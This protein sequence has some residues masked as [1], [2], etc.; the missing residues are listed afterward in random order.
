[1]PR[2]R[3]IL[4][5]IQDPI[6][7][8]LSTVIGGPPGKRARLGDRR[9]WLPV[10]VLVFFAV[11]ACTLSWVNKSM[12]ATHGYRAEYQYTRVCYSDVLALYY[13]EGLNNGRVPILDNVTPTPD[14]DGVV[15][16]KY[17]EYPVIIGGLMGAAQGITHALVSPTS[18]ERRSIDAAKQPGANDAAKNAASSATGVLQ[19]RRA[20]FFFN[21]T[22]AFLLLCGVAVVVLTGLTA[23]RRRIWDAA[24]VGLAPALVLHADV[25]WDL[26][27]V[28]FTAGALF[29]WSRKAP[30][31]AGMLLGFGIAT[32]FYPLLLLV[33]MF[34]LCLRAGQLR[35]YWRMVAAAVVAWSVTSIPVWIASPAGFG[36][37]YAL[38]RSR[39]TEYNSLFY[40]FQYFVFGANHPW[41]PGK[42]SPTWLNFWSGLLLAAAL[43]GI[44][45]IILL[46][47]RRPRLGQVGFLTIFAFLITNKVYSPQ[48]VLWL[49]P[50]VA[51]AR[52]KWR[53]WLIWQATEIVLLLT[54]Y[55]HLILADTGNRRGIWYPEFFW[56][57]LIPR[58]VVLVLICVL[59]IREIWHPE[60]DIVRSDGSDDPAGGVLDGAPDW[61]HRSQHSE[62]VVYADGMSLLRG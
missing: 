61:P 2:D 27:A 13:A 56:L 4:P 44:V 21:I 14:A 57:G 6:I 62:P 30:A 49:L 15:H 47:P 20:K 26:A 43:V 32:K 9:W 18:G 22:A 1:V 45:G 23:G 25:N 42:S 36:Q 34:A 35:A 8:A 10:R 17:V 39:G 31:V 51:L 59:V 53:V 55:W 28:A 5:S 3:L 46:A 11:V 40:S 24:F 48:Y 58:D 16:H 60:R 54:L 50:F 38:S 19:A 52:P 37:F 12:C 33:P 7:G 29:A 41:D